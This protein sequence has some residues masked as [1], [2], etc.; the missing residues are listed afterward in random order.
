MSQNFLAIIDYK[1]GNQTSVLRALRSLGVPATISSDLSALKEAAGVIFPGVGAA[2]KAMEV[3]KATG[4][5]FGI[6]ELGV[7]GTPFLGV[8]LGCQI[9]LD[10]SE[11]NGTE[12]LGIFPGKNLRFD[13]KK[14]D[15]EGNNIRVPHMGWNKV[16]IVKDKVPIFE[17]VSPESQF[18]FVHSYYPSPDPSL[19]LGLTRHGSEFCSV[20]G[21]DGIWALQFHPEKSGPPGLKILKNFYDYSV[22]IRKGPPRYAE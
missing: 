13:P 11:E 15:E 21:K 7:T 6:K 17:G 10:S 20:F 12:T 3:L 16:R 8:C 19:V 18:Y 5:D 2:G 4:M 9:M 1:A 22:S 14:K